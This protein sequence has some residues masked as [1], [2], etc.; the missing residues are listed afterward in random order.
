MESCLTS[1]QLQGLQ[2]GDV[3]DF[4]AQAYIYMIRALQHTIVQSTIV[5]TILMAYL[6]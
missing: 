3:E 4:V 5:Q 2:L 1:A 6:Q